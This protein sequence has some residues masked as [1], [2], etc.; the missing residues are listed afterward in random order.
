MNNSKDNIPSLIAEC[1]QDVGVAVRP[2]HLPNDEEEIDSMMSLVDGLLF[3]YGTTTEN[4]SP[5]A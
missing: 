3:M 5:S 2:L 4:L 1:G